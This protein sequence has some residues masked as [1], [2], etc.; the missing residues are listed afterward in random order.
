M[1]VPQG[2]AEL[3]ASVAKSATFARSK[4]HGEL[5][6][7]LAAQAEA[8]QD[9]KESI[10][11]SAFFGRPADYDPKT[12]PVVR[13]E[14]RRLRDRLAEY[15][16]SEGA[17]EVDRLEIPRGSYR[18]TMVAAES[19]EVPAAPAPQ[20]TTRGPR[21]IVAAGVAVAAAILAWAV[22][23]L[24]TPTPVVTSI[25]V[26]PLTPSGA[27]GDPNGLGS[28]LSGAITDSLARAG[29]LRV[30]GPEA[31]AR[32]KARGISDPAEI[33]NLLG[34]D[35]VLTGELISDGQR[36]RSQVR[37][38]LASNREVIWSGSLQRDIVDLFV[39]QDE[40]ATS[41][42]RAIHRDLVR[43]TAAV[44]RRQ[45]AQSTLVAYERGLKL[46]DRR[47]EP[48]IRE[49]IQSFR[50]AIAIDPNFAA[51]WTAL[52]D[53]LATAPDYYPPETGWAEEATS[54]AKRAIELDPENAAAAY[55]ALAW[56]EFE[57]SLHVNSARQYLQKA[58][59]LNPSHVASHRRLGLLLCIR[60]QFDQAEQH[61]RTA[62]QLDPLSNIARV[63]LAEMYFY[64][65]DYRREVDELQLVLRESPNFA[66]AQ[67]MMAQAKRNLGD[68]SGAIAEAKRLAGN[69]D[70]EGWKASIAS[71]RAECGDRAMAEEL[72]NSGDPSLREGVAQALGQTS[73]VR[74][75]F[76]RMVQSQPS[77]VLIHARGP[78]RERLR[79]DPAIAA[80]FDGLE[81]R[82]LRP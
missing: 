81:S 74:R 37:I 35:A 70:S 20:T 45:V 1:L 72:W 12:D 26:L 51:G 80:L 5:L 29:G 44:P 24:R 38:N 17:A 8:G 21:W 77:T 14:I 19:E 39:L 62:L 55:S 13:V 47:S 6:Q 9:L 11:G 61:L 33:A 34:V 41:V 31:A 63:N 60:K 82:V 16:R 79:R 7:Y 22:V 65:G 32:A 69:P 64:R 25:A 56:T 46:M 57:R 71:I 52:A 54:A 73:T 30:V 50:I 75:N 3:A 66:V 23:T 76:E 53:A 43:S 59:E 78:D 36:L 4:R 58:V 42:A 68:C 10:I 27:S 2:L 18:L 49:A 40:I 67:I 48:A 28:S 15:Y